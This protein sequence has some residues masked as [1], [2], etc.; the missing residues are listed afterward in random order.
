MWMDPSASSGAPLLLQTT[1]EV[2]GGGKGVV[3]VLV[4]VCGVRPKRK[5]G[6]GLLDR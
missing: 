5:R 3:D 6:G 1:G 4:V 2:G